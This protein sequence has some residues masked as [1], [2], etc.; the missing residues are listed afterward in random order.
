MRIGDVAAVGW[1]VVEVGRESGGAAREGEEAQKLDEKGS[2]IYA[3]AR[4]MQANLRNPIDDEN[5]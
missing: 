3:G 2:L 5:L 4:L 1:A